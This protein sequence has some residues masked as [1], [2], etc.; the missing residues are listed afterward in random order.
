M[1]TTQFATQRF[2]N[3]GW[4]SFCRREAI[5]WRWCQ[6]MAVAPSYIRRAQRILAG[7][8]YEWHEDTARKASVELS[9]DRGRRHR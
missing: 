8:R 5:T 2:I 9:L 1:R 4:W 7:R 6:F 3:T